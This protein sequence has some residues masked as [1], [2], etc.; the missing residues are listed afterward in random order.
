MEL[1]EAWIFNSMH[2][3]TGFWCQLI[4][5]VA[6]EQRA[7]LGRFNSTLTFYIYQEEHGKHNR[8]HFHALIN[9]EKVASVYL[10]NFEIDYLNSK[11]KQS[12]KKNIEE[13]IKKNI[14]VLKEICI[15]ENGRFDIP[16]NALWRNHYER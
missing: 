4:G 8:M 16:F 11:V 2:N 5:I 6:V 10:D 3:F 14:T 15:G 13:W 1:M 7:R 9:N 12:D